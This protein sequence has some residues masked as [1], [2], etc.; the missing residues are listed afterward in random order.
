MQLSCA[1]LVGAKLRGRF[2]TLQKHQ[3]ALSN[4]LNEAMMGVNDSVSTVLAWERAL[5]SLKKSLPS[6]DLKRLQLPVSPADLV[7]HVETW[8]A[9][10]PGRTRKAINV[11][12]QTVS[13]I[14]RFSS[15]VDQLAQGSPAPATLLWGSIK[16]VLT[17][18]IQGLA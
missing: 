18:C 15:C 3:S 6:K 14:Q 8:L 16:F 7:S 12:G 10:K 1:N 4:S 17:V 11:M 2:N 9:S 5:G 13:R